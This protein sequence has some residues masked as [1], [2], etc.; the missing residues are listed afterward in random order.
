M[1]TTNPTEGS[2]S[3]NLACVQGSYYLAAGLWPLLNM[4]SFERVTGP[5]LERWLVKTVGLL[6]GVAGTALIVGSRANE[7]R[8]V[9]VL[10]LGASAS[11]GAISLIYA[12]KRR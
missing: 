11:L 7:R 2:T 4:R 10:G 3:K 8:S 12:A 1:E 6:L 9:A 5:K